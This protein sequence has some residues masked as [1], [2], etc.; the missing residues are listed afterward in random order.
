M[1][2]DFEEKETNFNWFFHGHFVPFHTKMNEIEKLSHP[3]PL[4]NSSFLSMA[5]K[6]VRGKNSKIEKHNVVVH[7]KRILLVC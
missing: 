4:T 1:N 7:N 6:A 3:F 2:S 5:F